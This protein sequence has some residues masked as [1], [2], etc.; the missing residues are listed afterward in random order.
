ML[1]L[2]VL[3][4]IAGALASMLGVKPRQSALLASLA[5]LAL[6]AFLIAGFAAPAPE[7]F[8]YLASFD[9]VAAID[10][11]MLVGLDGLGAMM[12]LLTS[13]VTVCAIQLSPQPKHSEGAYFGSLML[14]SAG[15]QGAFISLDLFFLYAFH[16]LA[17]IPTF[18][19]IGIW[20]HGDRIQAAWKIT[21]YLALGS[22]VLL[23]GLLGLYVSLPAGTRTFDLTKLYA[24]QQGAGGA[25][26]PVGEQGWIFLTLLIGFGILISLFPFHTWAPTGYAAAP[27]PAAMLHAGVLKKF[28]LFGL[29]RIAYPLLPQGAQAYGNLL[30]WLLAGN[31]LYV[32]LVTIAQRRLDQMLGYSSVMHMG[33][34]FLGL[35][36]LNVIGQS[37]AALLLFAHGLSVAA[38]LGVMGD[39]RERLGTTQMEDLGGLAR[40]MPN[41]CLFFGLAL[42]ASIGLPG[43]ANF[44]AEVLV[45][46]GAFGATPVNVNGL[47]NFSPIQWAVIVAL[48][49][50]VIS[51]VYM[52]RA[53]RNIFFG[54]LRDAH[55]QQVDLAPAHRWPFALLA[56][57]LLVVGFYPK[58][59]LELIKP[60]VQPVATTK[61]AQN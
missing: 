12:V 45:F 44:A 47:L 26:I 29:L 16:E 23:L 15:C 52:L 28:G 61:V 27:T 2:L 25:L 9:V 14:I 49:G 54:P 32:G 24:L 8:R 53:F 1:Y 46:F 40:V 17:L 60:G 10:L 57:G 4:P 50:V 51:A 37:G 36:S 5:M 21:I 55:R 58:A 43:F 31:I 22:F 11:K 48:W 56:A 18:L 42:F 13:I 33:Y 7:K 41:L 30:L 35:A 19:L 38:L 3:I 39:L 34:I 20:G 6:S 59:L